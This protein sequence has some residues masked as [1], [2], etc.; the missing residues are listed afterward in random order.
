MGSLSFAQ[1]TIERTEWGQQSIKALVAQGEAFKH[2][3]ALLPNALGNLLFLLIRSVCA[4]QPLWGLVAV[5]SGHS[6]A[7][8]EVSGQISIDF[9]WSSPRLFGVFSVFP[10]KK[11]F[12]L[13][14]WHH[15]MQPTVKSMPLV[16]TDVQIHRSDFLS[17]NNISLWHSNHGSW[18]LQD[19][20]PLEKAS[21]FR[22]ES[23]FQQLSIREINHFK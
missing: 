18:T 22:E 6:S 2:S 14:L 10:N 9:K 7:P 19:K 15:M 23:M 16:C 12:L 21:G 4:K 11:F 20:K 1:V 13:K 5:V 3:C 8:I 17:D